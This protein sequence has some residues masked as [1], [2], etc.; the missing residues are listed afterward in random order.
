MSSIVGRFKKTD[1]DKSLYNNQ[2]WREASHRYLRNNPLCVHCLRVGRTTTSTETDHIKPHRGNKELFWDKSNWQALCKQCHALKTSSETRAYLRYPN[3]YN[4]PTCDVVLVCCPT[5]CDYITYIRTLDGLGVVVAE[6]MMSDE[7][8]RLV[9]HNAFIK[10]INSID[11]PQHYVA[12]VVIHEPS[13]KVRQHY[14][15]Q[16]NASSIVCLV[17]EDNN[18]ETIEYNN[19][20]VKTDKDTLVYV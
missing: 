15:E 11:Y 14:A 2:R 6:D 20:F 7:R 13:H 5:T 12:Y 1:A 4:K 17:C 19:K 3:V 18:K 10:Q 9:A 8:E 16:L